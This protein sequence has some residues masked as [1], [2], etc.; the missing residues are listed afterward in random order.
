MAS[1]GLSFRLASLLILWRREWRCLAYFPCPPGL[2]WLLHSL[3][4]QDGASEL[5]RGLSGGAVLHLF[6]ARIGG[7]VV[8]ACL[9]ALGEAGMP[10]SSNPR[11]T[12]NMGWLMGFEILCGRFPEFPV[13]WE[14]A[15]AAV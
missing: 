15:D 7:V 11:A 6:P 12:V 13:C 9:P 3:Q 5:S 1:V 4:T 14:G 2:T 10:V 8:V